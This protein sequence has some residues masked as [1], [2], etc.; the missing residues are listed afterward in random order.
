MQKVKS[1]ILAVAL[2]AVASCPLFAGPGDKAVVTLEWDPVDLV[3]EIL[4]INM[5]WSETLQGTIEN[6]DESAATWV[7]IATFGPTDTMAVLPADR[8]SGFYVLTCYNLW[9]ESDFSNGV[10][11]GAIP[12]NT[13]LN[14]RILQVTPVE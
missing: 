3:Q 7:K 6:P 9:G 12:A 8:P 1:I 13:T 14:L 2:L 11:I 10:E 5:Y 4:G